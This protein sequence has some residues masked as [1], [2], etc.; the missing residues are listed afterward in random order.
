MWKAY[1]DLAKILFPNAIIITDKY[2]FMRQVT[3]AIE[4]V[5]KNVQKKLS[6]QQRK[7]FKRSKS[8]ITK[9][10]RTLSQ[11]DKEALEVMFWQSDTLRIAHIIKEEFWK[12]CSM[13]DIKEQRVAL[14]KWIYETEN[15]KISEFKNC[16]TAFHNWFNKIMNAFEYGY[17]NGHLDI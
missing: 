7:Y 6:T 15:S 8:L 14:S 12:I 10:Y 1:A 13:T 11:E 5:R 9:P 17:T 16:T 2:H 4:G 3:W